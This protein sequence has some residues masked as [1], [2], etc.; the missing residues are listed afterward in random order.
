MNITV[1]GESREVAANTSVEAL[2]RELGYHCEQV[3]VAV[4]TTFV[5]RTL[6]ASHLLRDGDTLDV[7]APMEGG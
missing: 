7:V 1:N 4:N 2:L 6:R 3:A 5:P